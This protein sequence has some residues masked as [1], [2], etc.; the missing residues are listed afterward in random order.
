[1]TSTIKFTDILY[2]LAEVAVYVAVVWWGL[3]REISTPARWV[4]AVG[5]FAVF[6]VSWGLVAAPRASWHLPGAA[7]LAFRLIWF[8]LGLAAAVTVVAEAV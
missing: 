3:T 1:M 2:F 5:L 6:A 7:D 8:G 4:L